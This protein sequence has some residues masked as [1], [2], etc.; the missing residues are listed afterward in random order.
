MATREKIKV[1]K[2][3]IAKWAKSK[4]AGKAIQKAFRLSEKSIAS[5]REARRID[6]ET[7][8]KPITL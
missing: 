7:L 4:Q 1:Q 3:D 5:L 8:N 2:K 6:P